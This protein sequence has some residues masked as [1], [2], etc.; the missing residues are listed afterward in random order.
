MFVEVAGATAAAIF[1]S[2]FALVAF[3][4]DSVIELISAFVVRR[5]L[6]LDGSGSIAQGEKTALLTSLLLASLVPVIGLGSTYAYFFLNV[7]PHASLLGIA[8]ALG[9]VAIMPVLWLDKRKIGRET[10]C[11][12]LSIDA[13][14]S[15]TCFFMSLTL[16]TGLV[17][18]YV[19]NLAWIDY[20]A[21]LL[22]VCFVAY[23]A[24]ES[25]SEIVALKSSL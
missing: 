7:R 13:I 17:A 24:K 3:G 14:E 6:S 18:E 25:L 11:L 4:A 19:F 1:A 23:E 9:S 12:P 20:A 8:I 21:S 15:A 5:H 2:S 22:I 16:L 10:G